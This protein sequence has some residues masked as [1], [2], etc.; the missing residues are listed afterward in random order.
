MS[1]AFAP[2]TEA[3]ARLVGA[4]GSAAELTRNQV[5]CGAL[6]AHSGDVARA[7]DLARQ[8]LDAFGDGEAPI[9][10]NAAGCGAMLKHYGQLLPDDPRAERLARRVQD[11]SEFLAQR[12]P[13]QPPRAVPLRV[14]IQDPCHLLHAQRISAAPRD[15]LRAIPRLDVREIEE[16]EICCGSAGV[17]N[18]T[19]PNESR[20]L[21]QRKLDH[22]ATTKAQVIVT[23]NPGCLIQLQSGLDERGEPTQVKHIVELLDEATAPD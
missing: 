5:C 17:Y 6:Q 7:R 23:A 12:Q 4:F 1:T 22:A 11:V 13:L 3:T 18:L 16:K 20:Q 8:N 21:Q 14:A 2:T 10:V 9:V 19:N 15:L